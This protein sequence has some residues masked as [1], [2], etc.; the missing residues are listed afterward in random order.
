MSGDTSR[1]RGSAGGRRTRIEG[2]RVGRHNVRTSPEEEGQLQRLA[3]AQG[4]SVPRYLVESGLAMEAGETITDRRATIAK[5][6][7]LHRLLAAISNNVNQIAKATNST[8]ERQA[9][10]TATLDA[11]RRIAERIDAAVDELS[12]S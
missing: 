8:G 5:L 12:L 4:V 6:F 9:E 10:T 11:V 1:E 3:R 2:G 7:E